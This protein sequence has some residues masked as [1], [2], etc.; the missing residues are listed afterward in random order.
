[1]KIYGNQRGIPMHGLGIYIL[2]SHC[3]VARQLSTSFEFGL[4]INSRNTEILS[5]T[6]TYK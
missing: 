2:L 5:C 1:M 4:R 6:S 3:D